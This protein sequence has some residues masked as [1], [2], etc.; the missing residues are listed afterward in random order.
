MYTKIHDFGGTNAHYNRA[1]ELYILMYSQHPYLPKANRIYR[2]NEQ[3]IGI[4]MMLYQLKP[5]NFS[6]TRSTYQLLQALEYL[7]QSNIVHNDIKIENI[8]F[9]DHS[10]AILIDFDSS[11]I[12]ESHQEDLK[13]LLTTPTSSAPEVF[14]ENI[15][16]K[17]TDIWALGVSL[18][19]MISTDL[20]A[21]RKKPNDWNY[22]DY[23][24]YLTG[25]ILNRNYLSNLNVNDSL[26]DLLLQM[27]HPD[28]TKRPTAKE[29]LSY[30]CFNKFN[31]PV[32]Y[33]PLPDRS[34]FFDKYFD[35]NSHYSNRYDGGSF[36]KILF[37]HLLI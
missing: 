37:E 32:L 23:Y 30:P 1:M 7:H 2:V 28:P 14:H 34:Q 19:S 5:A 18:I 13:M 33:E 36:T 10:N 12:L 8:L 21:E 9:D 25:K 3:K 26:I 16:S 15:Y 31:L 11:M 4:E 29:A 20:R 6:L 35:K 24:R 27:T 22:V 17:A